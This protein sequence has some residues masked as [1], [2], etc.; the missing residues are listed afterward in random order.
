MG[1]PR[2]GRC[3]CG[4]VCFTVTG[5]PVLVFACHCTACQRRSGSAFTVSM[6]VADRHFRLTR[7]TLAAQTRV[8]DSGAPLTHRFCTGCGTPI[9]GAERGSAPDLYQAV[10]VGA[11]DDVSGIVPTMHCW[12]RSAQAWVAI[13][14]GPRS[15][16]RNPTVPF[17]TLAEPS[18]F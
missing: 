16:E 2:D 18:N 13:P 17:M 10:R 1:F 3:Q 6:V 12:T 4:A 5:R 7:G 8:A 15:F 9:L 11:L 14:A